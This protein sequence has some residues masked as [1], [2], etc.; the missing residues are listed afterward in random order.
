MATAQ[1]ARVCAITGLVFPRKHASDS[2]ITFSLRKRKE[3]GWASGLCVR[4]LNHMAARSRP[5][6]LRVGAR[7]STLLF[8]QV[9]QLCDDPSKKLGF[10][11]RRRPIGASRFAALVQI[12]R[13]YRG[14][15][16]L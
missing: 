1:F 15:V 14:N 7:G 3:W 13:V 10:C 2:S 5:K 9:A 4:S 8:R 16:C 11:D 6:M 12:R